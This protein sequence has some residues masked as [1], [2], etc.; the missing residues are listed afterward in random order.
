MISI[1]EHNNKK[2]TFWTCV[3]GKEDWKDRKIGCTYRY[4]EPTPAELEKL[5]N[6]KK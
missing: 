2:C 1:T 6:D 4:R 3:D 5:K